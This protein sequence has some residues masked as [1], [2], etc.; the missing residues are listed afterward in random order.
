MKTPYR[1]VLLYTLRT[2]IAI[3]GL[4]VSCL[5]G[6]FAATSAATTATNSASLK[7]HVPSP[8]WRDQIIYFLVTDRF[9]DGDPANNDLG[10]GEYD[11]TSNAKYN[12]GDLKGV[13]QKLD[14]IKGLGATAIW[15][16]PPVANQW[17]DPQVQ[18]SGFHGYWAEN[19]MAVDRH[20][21]TLGDYQ[22]LSHAIHTA[23]MY[24]VQDIVVNHTGNFFSYQGSWDARDPAKHFA[25]NP[26][27]QP[28]QAPSQWPFS[29]ND[30]RNPDHRRAGIYHWTPNVVDFSD[31]KQ[32]MNFQ[33][34]GLDDINTENP[35]VRQVLRES[36]GYWIKEVGVDAFRVDTAFYVPASYFADFMYSRDPRH[37]G[38]ANVARA[39]GRNDF[40]VF[41]E[42]FGIDKP[43]T[44]I[45]ARKIDRYM[46]SP[47]G[48][49][50]LPGMINFPLYGTMGDVFARGRPT[51][52]LA[53]RIVRMMTLHKRPHLMP[54]FV[55]NHDVDRFLAGATQAAL[56]QSLLL[57]M[58]LPGIPTIYYGTEQ[59]FTEPRAAMFKVGFQSGG[60]DRFDTDAPLYRYIAA[61]SELRKSNRLFSRGT[62]TILK[63]NAATAGALAYR[64]SLGKDAAIV[65][66]NTSSNETLLD[67]MET[68]LPAG[69]LLTG[70]F[71][72]DGAPADMIVGAQGRVSMKLAPR[73][74]M[75]W[76][77]SNARRSVPQLS[78]SITMENLAK[79]MMRGDFA[80]AGRARGITSF[81]LVTDGDIAAAPSIT[82]AADGRWTATVD[83]RSMLDAGIQHSI[84]AWAELSAEPPGLASPTRTFRVARNWMPLADVVDPPG[85]DVGPR[86][87]YLY[88]T[89]P[90]WASGRTLDMRRVTVSGAAGALKIDVKMSNIATAWNPQNGFDHVAFT[91]FIEIPGRDGG[92]TAMPLQ[93]ASLP[94]GMRWHYR[95][96]AHGWS[97][98]V[99]SA[100]GASATNEGTSITPAADIRV[101]KANSTVTFILAASAL[102]NPKSLSGAKL[103]LT[104][105]DYDGGYRQLALTAD[106]GRFGGGDPLT[107][108]RVMDDTR[109]IVLP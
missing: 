25:L 33:M 54:T 23:G 24:L 34:S 93:N 40:H 39:T 91:V 69:T 6:A 61:V 106:P 62:P 4:A 56:K 94:A 48:E 8:D 31:P 29:L 47:K 36:Y 60:R 7:L 30:A 66:F 38:M 79:P 50:L 108:P 98:A 12:G 27:S 21:G 77:V 2:A 42:G 55:D 102:G 52:E 58:T 11:P 46:T 19:F 104:T 17:W 80:V 97:N 5:P 86:G 37:P 85:D 92:V 75:V 73:S 13:E 74:G 65:V 1:R 35:L 96:R 16:T 43:F 99:F 26:G 20:L 90:T 87:T 15:I 3:T 9:N 53:H 72:I 59:A 45:Y 70:L 32:E 89:D 95:L 78:A 49:P 71:G 109:V 68:R 101:D 51:A 14:Y 57:M 44:D 107:D 67:N 88:P 63:D 84:V 76:K 64:M 22:R 83:T 81:K 100:D 41:G 18:F 105:W 10:A 28:V 82:P 103:Y